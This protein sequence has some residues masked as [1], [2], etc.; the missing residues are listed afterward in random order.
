MVFF[1][2]DTGTQTD[3]SYHFEQLSVR[4][5]NRRASLQSLYEHAAPYLKI[6]GRNGTYDRRTSYRPVSNTSLYGTVRY[7]N[8]RNK[9]KQFSKSKE[10]N[11]S[12]RN[13]N[14][15]L[16]D[17]LT[18]AAILRITTPEYGILLGCTVLNILLTKRNATKRYYLP[19]SRRK[20]G[21]NGYK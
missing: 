20:S 21:T 7:R 10:K 18:H 15:V 9:P 4:P 1:S 19:S 13:G 12:K 6:N 11:T 5:S 8:K 16:D 2:R 3:G 17:V 14:V